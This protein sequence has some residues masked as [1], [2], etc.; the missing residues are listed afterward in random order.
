[1]ILTRDLP[2]SLSATPVAAR[3]SV[4]DVGEFQRQPGPGHLVGD[5]APAAEETRGDSAAQHPLDTGPSPSASRPSPPAPPRSANTCSTRPA[6][7]VATALGYHHVT[8]ARLAAEAGPPA[9]GNICSESARRRE[10]T[11]GQ[12]WSPTGTDGHTTGRRAIRV[13][14]VGRIAPPATPLVSGGC[15]RVLVVTAGQ[16]A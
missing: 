8:T 16:V 13:R 1:M 12:P 15:Y 6:P 9:P 5:L 3:S 2:P 4:F 11:A 14:S 10:V 7:I